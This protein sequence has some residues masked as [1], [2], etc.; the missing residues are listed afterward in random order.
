M[1]NLFW[2]LEYVT[3]GPFGGPLSVN[4]THVQKVRQ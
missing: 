4:F 1:L 2:F 3:A